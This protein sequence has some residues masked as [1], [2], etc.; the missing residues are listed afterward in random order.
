MWSTIHI[1]VTILSCISCI[2]IVLW[3]FRPHSKEIYDECKMI[4]IQ[5]E[6]DKR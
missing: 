5:D 6:D 2:G 1:I 4:P 3:I